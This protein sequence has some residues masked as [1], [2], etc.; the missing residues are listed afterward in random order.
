MDSE[1]LCTSATS[2]LL[3]GKAFEV[4]NWGKQNSAVSQHAGQTCVSLVVLRRDRMKRI[5]SRETFKVHVLLPLSSSAR[6]NPGNFQNGAT[7]KA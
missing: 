1:P 4:A 2:R 3:G 7:C 5:E 6:K